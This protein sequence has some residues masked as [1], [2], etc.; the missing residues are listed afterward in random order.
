[1]VTLIDDSQRMAALDRAN[2]IRMRR[3]AL[4]RDLHDRTCRI[5]DVLRE[6]EWFVFTA[7]IFEVLGWAPRTG[8]WRI[9]KVL[10]RA[11][12]WPLRETGRLTSA[13]RTRV[14]AELAIIREQG[15]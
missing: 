6:P 13:Q 1:M 12:V 15:R 4:K 8:T 9:N 7:P 11:D 3:R 5:E 10:R 14:L 2:D